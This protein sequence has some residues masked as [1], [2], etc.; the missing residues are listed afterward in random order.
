MCFL[1]DTVYIGY[2]NVIPYIKF[3]NFGIIRFSYDMDKQTD[4]NML[5]TLT[6][7]SSKM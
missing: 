2:H 1:W 3:E 5:P 4:W 6:D 7:N